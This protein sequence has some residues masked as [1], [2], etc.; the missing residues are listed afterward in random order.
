[1]F[2]FERVHFNFSLLLKCIA[3][4][5]I[6][7]EYLGNTD[8]V[9]ATYASHTEYLVNYLTKLIPANYST[10]LSDKFYSNSFMQFC[11]ISVLAA[12][13]FAKEQLN[14]A[15]DFAAYIGYP[16]VLKPTNGSEGNFVYANLQNEKEFRFAFEDFSHFTTLCNMMVEKHFEGKD[17]RFFVIDG[18]EEPFVILRTIPEIVG[19]GKHSIK[20]LI[21]QENYRRTN[22]RNTCLGELYIGDGEALRVL[23]HQKLTPDSVVDKGKHVQLRYNANVCWGGECETINNELI[24][25]SYLQLAKRIHNFLPESK[26]SMVDILVHDIQKPCTEKNYAFCEFNVT[27]GF[28]LHHMPSRGKPQNVLDPFVDLLFPETKEM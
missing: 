16:V 20:E 2:D 10:L 6:H 27:P 3:K 12:R 25:H 1:M 9:V 24:H 26:F 23:H 13:V 18:V 5:G 8:A 7:L 15:C 21:E 28:S 17:Y 11:G 4:R 22:P 19:D 14:Q